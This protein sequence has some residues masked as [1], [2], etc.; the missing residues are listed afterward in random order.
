[1][2]IEILFNAE[3]QGDERL[4]F[5]SNKA[6]SKS[7]FLNRKN[8][9][10]LTALHYA[11]FRGNIP[12]IKLLI[13]HGANP[14]VKDKDGHNVIH[15]AAQGDQVATIYYFITNYNFDL[16]DRDKRESTPLHWAAYLNKEIALSFL[17]AW[18]ADPNSTDAD[19]NTPLHLA[20]VTATKVKESRWAKILLLKGANRNNT[21]SD[22]KKPIDLVKP[23]EMEA[24]LNDIL[25]EPKFCTW[26]MLK[27]PLK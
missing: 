13:S 20:V 14:F 9:D 6:A 22:D 10:G 27:V 18:G 17:I 11:A 12:I 16:N 4:S 25:K 24:E 1:M 23:G 2:I 19:S 15:I 5:G 21:N 8:V 26:L 7:E 3:K